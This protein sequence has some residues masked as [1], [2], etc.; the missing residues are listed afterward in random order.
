MYAGN[1][2]ANKLLLIIF[3][4]LF[5]IAGY[6]MSAAMEPDANFIVWD[7]NLKEILKEPFSQFYWNQ[8]SLIV[9][10]IMIGVYV[11]FLL[12]YLTSLKNYMPGKEYG[13]AK[14][15]DIKQLNKKLADLN[16]DKNASHNIVV[17][18]KRFSKGD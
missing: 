6:Y 15:A 16:N 4:F 18:E 3:F 8:Y 12:Y 10:S 5:V 17:I 1:K 2:K 7:A 13:T 11:F 9:I 14:Y